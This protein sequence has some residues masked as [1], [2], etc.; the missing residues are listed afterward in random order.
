M[1]FI[2]KVTL[3]HFV[4]KGENMRPNCF[5][6]P[7]IPILPARHIPTLPTQPLPLYFNNFVQKNTTR[8]TLII[9]TMHN[10]RLHKIIKKNTHQ[11]RKICLTRAKNTSPRPKMTTFPL[12][13]DRK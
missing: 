2:Y 7:F 4:I 11:N 6:S 8:K 13:N 12:K 5:Q 1:V 9:N 3:K 10:A